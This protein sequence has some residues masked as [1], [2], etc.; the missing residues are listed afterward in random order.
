M[1]IKQLNDVD[2]YT[3]QTFALIVTR[4]NI[5]V[6]LSKCHLCYLDGNMQM[7]YHPSKLD[8]KSY[9]LEFEELM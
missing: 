6:S 7:I 2:E 9:I 5:L 1:T 3:V 4:K 8:I